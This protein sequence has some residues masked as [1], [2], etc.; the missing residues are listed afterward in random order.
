MSE[1]VQL[2]VCQRASDKVERQ[3]EIGLGGISF[4][5]YEALGAILTREKYVKIKLMNW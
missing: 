3:V 1:G 2:R 5:A 4:I